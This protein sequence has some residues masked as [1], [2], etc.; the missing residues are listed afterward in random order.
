MRSAFIQDNP[1]P[2]QLNTKMMPQKP[3]IMAHGANRAINHED[4]INTTEQNLTAA[5]L[6]PLP[7]PLP[8]TG[9]D[10]YTS[11]NFYIH[12]QNLI[13]TLMSST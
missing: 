5:I 12:L 2:R 11:T 9:T 3:L 4:L 6:G 8:L 1:F 10:D 13:S 7:R